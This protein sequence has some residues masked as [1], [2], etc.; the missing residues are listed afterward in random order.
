MKDEMSGKML[1]LAYSKETD[2]SCIVCV[3]VDLR[4]LVLVPFSVLT[5]KATRGDYSY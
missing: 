2:V 3:F 5:E 4:L 1:I